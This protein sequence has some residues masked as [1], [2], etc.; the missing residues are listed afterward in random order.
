MIT[1]EGEE[2]FCGHDITDEEWKALRFGHWLTA[3]LLVE[4]ARKKTFDERAEIVVGLNQV[5]IE[6]SGTEQENELA[7][8]AIRICGLSDQALDKILSDFKSP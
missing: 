1:P 6:F 4:E 7:E 8:L 2:R 3:K 5:N